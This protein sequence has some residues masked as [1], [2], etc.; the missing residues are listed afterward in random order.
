MGTRF[1]P[2]MVVARL[3]LVSFVVSLATVSEAGSA[4]AGSVGRGERASRLDALR[5]QDLLAVHATDSSGDDARLGADGHEDTWWTGRPSEPQWRWSAVFVRPVHLGVV[6]ARFGT[7][8]TSGVPTEFHWEVRPPAPWAATCDPDPTPGDD[9]WTVVEGADQPAPP[10]ATLLAEPTRR[11]WFIDAD[12]CALRLVIDRTTAGPPVLREVQAIESARDVLRNA[13]ASDDGAYP[14]FRAADAVDGTYERRWAGATGKSRWV[15]HLALR[16]PEPIDRVRLVLGFDATT[17]SRAGGGR[18]YAMAWAP[19]RYTLEASEDGRRFV[20]VAS[21]PRRKD[22]TILPLRRRLVSFAE[23]HT[24]RALRLVM[25]GAVGE[26]G[27]P[28]AGA[29]PVV[30]E[31]SAYRADDNRPVL[32]TPWILSVNANP[33]AQSHGSPGGEWIND[34]YHAKFLQRRFLQLLPALRRDDVYARSLGP[35][36]ELLAA[37]PGDSAG[38]ALESIEGD[39]PQLDEQLLA[40]SSPPPIVVLSGSNDWDYAS[41]TGP[42]PTRPRQWRWDP[43]RDARAGGMGQLGP[44]VRDRVAPFMGFCGGAQILALLEA[45][46]S[47]SASSDDDQ[48]LIDLVLRRTS[49]RPIRGFAPPVDV[50]RSWPGDPHPRRATIR[51]LPEDPLFVDLAGPLGRSTTQALPESHVDAVRPDAFLAGGPLERLEIVATSAFCAPNVVAASPRD[52]VFPNPAGSGSCD[53]VPE[54]FRTREGAWPIIGTQF[55]AEQR[56]F[57]VPGPGDPPE[58]VADPRL[59]LASAFEEMVDAYVRLAQ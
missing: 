51:F 54:V 9:G 6:R 26:G 22:G 30:R 3:A 44:A 52:G 56:D 17:V 34:V 21:E 39:D 10:P 4:A 1:D 15:L 43:L 28:G 27:V 40:G 49:G 24:V 32:A 45:P 7:S 38:E 41:S 55:H 46:R 5:T 37:P 59:F 11:S 12:A 20:T 36:G 8:P 13:D 29:V 50:E 19:V 57:A 48:R 31:I 58:S 14:G 23:P 16:E 42:D 35:R 18:S 53:T 33:S 2:T 25:E 47:D